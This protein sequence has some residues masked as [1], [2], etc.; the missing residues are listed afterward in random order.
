MGWD[1][2]LLD[3]HGER[4]MW[5]PLGMGGGDVVQE[6]TGEHPVCLAFD[7][8]DRVDHPRIRLHRLALAL[9]DVDGA[10]ERRV[11]HAACVTRDAMK[12]DPSLRLEV[13]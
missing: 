4:V 6:Y 10:A 2:D 7:T 5:S 11:F 13:S 12:R 8:G 1:M 9:S 3:R